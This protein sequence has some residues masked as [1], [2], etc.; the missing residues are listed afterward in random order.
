MS[1]APAERSRLYF[2]LAWFHAVVQERLRYSPLGWAK[3][4]EFNESDLKCAL[5]TIDTWVDS[6]AMGRTN[7]PP[8]KVPWAALRTLISQCI[9][10][11]KIDNAFDQRL[12]ETF[13]NNMFTE[14]SFEH[15]F[16]LVTN[17]D[18]KGSS[19]CIPDSAKR[20]D[21]INWARTQLPANQTPSWL[22]LPNNAEKVLLR[23]RGE[24]L[25]V[26]NT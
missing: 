9:Y 10:G 25:L 1:K 12:M 8:E 7:I 11:G 2:L 6:A 5:D 3:R 22:D 15:D 19:I 26:N 23:N 20:D 18:A 17:L 14:K 16:P 24:C 13:L 4:Y 21:L